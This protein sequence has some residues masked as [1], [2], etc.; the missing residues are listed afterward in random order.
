MEGLG[1]TRPIREEAVPAASSGSG[2]LAELQWRGGEAREKYG[3]S[4]AGWIRARGRLSGRIAPDLAG[5][6]KSGGEASS[7]R[8]GAPA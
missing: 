2:E 3:E 5:A 4:G 7:A 6:A 1:W 8:G